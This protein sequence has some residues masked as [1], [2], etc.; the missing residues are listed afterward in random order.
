[1]TLCIVWRLNWYRVISAAFAEALRRGW[2]VECWYWRGI[3]SDLHDNQPMHELA[4]TFSDAIVAKYFDHPEHIGGCLENSRPDVV[5]AVDV[6]PVDIVTICSALRKPPL[7]VIIEGLS[8]FPLQKVGIFPDSTYTLYH[9]SSTLRTRSQ[10]P[11][12]LQKNQE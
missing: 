2:A 6:K 10:C 11:C 12:L 4:P 8:H 3:R 7:T 9:R 5:L 1:M